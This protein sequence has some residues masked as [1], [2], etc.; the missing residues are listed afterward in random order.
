MGFPRQEY[1][2]GFPFPSPGHLSNSGI[3][4]GINLHCRQISLQSELPGKPKE[5]EGM[6]FV[7]V[8]SY[9]SRVEG[10][11]VGNRTERVLGFN[12][13]ITFICFH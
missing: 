8:S 6:C 12:D 2:G 11:T 10:W 4:P 13:P 3:K 5:G 9:G 1:W 7:S